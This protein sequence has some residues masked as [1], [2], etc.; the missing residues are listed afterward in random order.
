MLPKFNTLYG[1]NSY[2][3]N[4]PNQSLSPVTPQF[5]TNIDSHQIGKT[6]ISDEMKPKGISITFHSITE[7]NLGVRKTMEDFV[8]TDD[9]I[10]KDGRFAAF[11][12]LDGHGGAD[13]VKLVKNSYPRV[14]R[15][16]FQKYK[17]SS[18]LKEMVKKSLITIEG[19]IKMSGGRDCG[20][21]FC[22]LFIDKQTKIC[23]AANIGDSRMLRTNP[24]TFITSEH[25]VS[26]EAEA[27]R[28]LSSGGTIFKG[29]VGGT[30]MITR[31]LGDI[32]LKPYGVSSEPELILFPAQPAMYA[33]ASDGIWDKIEA[34]QFDRL[35]ISHTRKP[36]SELGTAVVNAAIKAGSNDNISLILVVIE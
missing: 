3:T 18:D 1:A 34:P 22:G 4:Q 21:T 9:D 13:V 31:S 15:E 32:E 8:I 23:L 24:G 11:I 5:R 7:P 27:K 28:I 35:A 14:L 2:H 10:I 16:T 17:D 33:I 19:M 30:L 12:V 20:T 6:E 36:L 29:R 25:K 26:N